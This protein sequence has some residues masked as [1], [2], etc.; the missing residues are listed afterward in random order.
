[1]YENKHEGQSYLHQHL[2][3]FFQHC[4]NCKVWLLST[5]TIKG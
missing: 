4:S 5:W 3:M 2:G 1:M